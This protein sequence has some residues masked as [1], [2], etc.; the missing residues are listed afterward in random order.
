MDAVELKNVLRESFPLV[1][2]GS[3]GV[4]A[5][6]DP[7][8]VGAAEALSGGRLSWAFLNQL[9]HRASEAGMS[10]GFFRYYFLYVPAR[11]PYD[12]RKVLSSTEYQPPDGCTHVES[13][14]QL[15]WGFTR[16][17]YDA[18]LFWGNFRQAYRDLRRLS[19]SA[20]EQNFSDRRFDEEFIR[21][22]GAIQPPKAIP[23]DHRYL[24]SEMACKT[25]EAPKNLEAA[26]HVQIA[27]QAFRELKSAGGE[28]T[29]ARLKER[30]KQVAEG[31]RQLGLFELM[32]EEAPQ[33]LTD[34][35]SVIA[36]YD[37]QWKAFSQARMDALENTR[38]YLSACSDLD[39]YVATSMRTRD[40]FR[41]MAA[42]CDR[43]FSA[44]ELAPYNIRYF[45]PTLSAAQH[46]EDKGLIECLMV[47]T[48]KML[49]YFAQYRESLGKI[50][51]Y[52]MA[53]SQ[54]KPV[55]VLCPDD[56]RGQ[57]LYSFYRDA[58]PLMRLVHFETGVVHGA[59]ITHKVDVAVELVRRVLSGGMEY[60]VALKPGTNG[61]YLLKDRLTGS[62]VR[63][64]TDDRLLTETFWN[65]WQGIS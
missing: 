54:G 44:A 25:Y 58:H 9:L 34:E 28:I 29:P 23:R 2:E 38:I 46:H 8:L 57:E 36:L 35:A 13:L 30:A 19:F 33:P 42:T 39:V 18:M 65:N 10:E 43:I 6:A 26:D 62:T 4:L 41:E 56:Q 48:A 11:H 63:I 37:G 52:A 47:K 51:E 27:L 12:V 55:I 40:D 31:Q 15:R 24:I 60:D 5:E 17:T 49:V 20:I 16:F 3:S 45:D 7:V 59:M 53:L 64:V 14:Q 32:Y 50:S 61:Y 1:A 21:L 22:R